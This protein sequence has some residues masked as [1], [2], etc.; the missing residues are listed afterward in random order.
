MRISRK[1][2]RELSALLLIFLAAPFV[3]ILLF[4]NGGFMELR[5]MQ[6]AL[7]ELQQENQRLREEHQAY[8]KRIEKLRQDPAE[9]ER[10]A[11]E[12]YN[13]ARPGDVIINLP[14]TSVD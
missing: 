1:A 11:R 14:R 13:Y 4:G 6:A 9:I 5:R 12:R 2:R 8:L 10:V 3:Y 7:Q